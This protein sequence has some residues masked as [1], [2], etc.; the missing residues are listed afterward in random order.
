MRLKSKLAGDN[1]AKKP[2]KTKTKNKETPLDML[3]EDKMDSPIHTN[4]IHSGGANHLIFI[5]DGAT[6]SVPSSRAQKLHWNMVVLLDDMTLRA[7]SCGCQ[8]KTVV[9]VPCLLTP[10]FRT[11]WCPNLGRHEWV[12]AIAKKNV[13]SKISILTF[14]AMGGN[15][16]IY[17]SLLDWP[18]AHA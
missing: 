15:P 17:A 8:I 9:L 14:S 11:F 10:V 16:P 18:S 3:R 5:V 1:F 6:P 7:N 2:K 13:V 4:C 12:G